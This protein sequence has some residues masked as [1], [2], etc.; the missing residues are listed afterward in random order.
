MSNEPKEYSNGEIAIVWK[1]EKCIHSANCVRSLPGVF[2]PHERPW[3][4]V[5]NADT[6]HLKETI[7]KCPSGALSWK[8]VK[9]EA[10]DKDVDKAVGESAKLNI[11]ADGPI[12]IKGNFEITDSKGNLLEKKESVALCRCGASENKPFCDGTHKKIGFKG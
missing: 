11:F 3:I 8:S 2:K 6:P 5:K 9:G 12:L 7:A 1:S 4:S 10:F